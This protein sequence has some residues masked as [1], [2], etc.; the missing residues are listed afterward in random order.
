MS[1]IEFLP[2]P[3]NTHL[4]QV[5]DCFVRMDVEGLR[6]LLIPEFL[7][8]DVPKD[9]FLESLDRFFENFRK[10]AAPF[11]HLLYYP[12]ACCHHSCD[13]HLGRQGFKFVTSEGDYFNLRFILEV[14]SSG[15]ESVKD[16][17]T[18]YRFVTN[19]WVDN[20]GKEYQF[21]VYEDDK[22]SVVRKPNHSILLSQAQEAFA[23]WKEKLECRPTTVAEIQAWLSR[24][25]NTYEEIGGYKGY[26]YEAVWKWDDFLKTYHDLK[27]YVYFLESFQADL[28]PYSQLI[29]SGKKLPEEDL[30]RWILDIETRLEERGFSY[31]FGCSFLLKEYAD[32][33]EVEINSST[34]VRLEDSL[35]LSV[36]Q[37]IHWFENERKILL[38]HYF[39]LTTTEVDEF[40]EHTQ[41]PWQLYEVGALLSYHLDI[42][43]KFRKEGIFIPFGMGCGRISDQK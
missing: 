29:N 8:S 38:D 23:N 25:I 37:L 15:K 24:Y 30:L 41:E 36:D 28:A 22:E 18:C 43:E 17:F 9:A 42:R 2:I 31:I 21:W 4:H 40:L 39:S 11:S 1:R 35:A 14:D 10:S 7:Y 16:I 20:L 5:L 3:M 27:R 26:G 34:T 32:F 13:P 19:E 12:G 33:Y 6:E